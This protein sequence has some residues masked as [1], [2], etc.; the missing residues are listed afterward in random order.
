MV[1]QNKGFF[2]SLVRSADLPGEAVPGQPL[3]EIA[4]ECRVLIENHSGVTVYGCKEIHVK[5]RFGQIC[6]CGRNL[7]LAQMTRNQL[8]VT[9]QIDS[10]SLCRGIKK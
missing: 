9:G 4:G 10:V 7:E 6:I 3:V 1:K 5:V 8:V 2:E